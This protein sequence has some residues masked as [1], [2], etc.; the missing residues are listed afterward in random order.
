MLSVRLNNRRSNQQ[1]SALAIALV[2]LLLLTLIGVTAMQTTT[3]QERMAGNVRDR[4][5]AFQA[6]EAAL[7]EGE[8][9]L[10]QAA[11]PQFNNT[12]GLLA[13][14][15]NPGMVTTWEAH[16]WAANSRLYTGNLPGVAEQ[17]RYVIE[18]LPPVQTAGDTARFGALPEV[19]VYR[20]TARGVG[21]TADAVVIL[22]T[23]F[24]R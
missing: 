13:P 4:S 24:R 19:G 2:F 17:P 22:Q 8:A 5:L 1:G 21:G 23:T 18:E 15:N 20:V 3:L 14:L 7:R 6:A 12:G 16:N 11:L 10:S 9:F